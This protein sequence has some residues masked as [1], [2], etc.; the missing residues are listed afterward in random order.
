LAIHSEKHLDAGIPTTRIMEI[1]AAS[2]V[3]ISDEN[4]YIK[5]HFKDQVLFFDQNQD[6]TTMFKQIDDHVK[7]VLSHPKE[8]KDLAKAAHGTYYDN[9]TAEQFLINLEKFH[10]NNH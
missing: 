10:K 7:W 2:A 9:Y 6:A 4:Q 3:A 1:A 8:A 5:K